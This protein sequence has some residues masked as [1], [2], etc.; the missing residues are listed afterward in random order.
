MAKRTPER[1]S[2][3]VAVLPAPVGSAA[4]P[5]GEAPIDEQ[6]HTIEELSEATGVAPRTIRFYQAEKLLQKP[7]RDR[8]DGRVARYSTAHV[9]RL[10]LIGELRDRGLKLP[11]IR[12]LLE[13]GDASSRV[14]DWL[15]LDSQLRGSWAGVE[16]KI[17]SNDELQEAIAGLPAGSRGVLEDGRLILRQGSSWLLPNPGLF[18]LTIRLIVDGVPG[19]S[20]TEAGEILRKSLA[21]AARELIELFVTMVAQG[22]GSGIDP[23]T[24]V[25]AF[26]P[27]AGEGAR[28]I[29]EQQLERAIDDLLNDTKRLTAL[30]TSAG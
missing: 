21:I 10:K 28:L 1:R 29:F 7:E 15:G 4:T 5:G 6:W 3:T 19:D 18:D 2:D 9:E 27:S 12:A 30:H 20:V 17:I 25:N 16:A 24:L 23:A 22:Y 14:A 8:S 11:G 13:D 26:K